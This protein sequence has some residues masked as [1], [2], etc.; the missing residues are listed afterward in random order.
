MVA[1]SRSDGSPTSA[2][3]QAPHTY[4]ANVFKHAEE[5]KINKMEK[6]DQ[7]ESSCTERKGR[8][9]MKV[10]RDTNQTG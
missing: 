8:N 7:E 5:D 3:N 6:E 9:K 1:C 10:T 4:T 2:R